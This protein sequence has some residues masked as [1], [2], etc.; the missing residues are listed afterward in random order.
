MSGAYDRFSVNHVEHG[1]SSKDL[2]D[3]YRLRHEIYCLEEQFLSSE[4]YPDGIQSDDYDALSEHFV[5]RENRMDKI[6]GCARL[7]KYSNELRFP[8]ADHFSELYSK[9]SDKPL[10]EVFEVS[11][12]CVSPD[13]RQRLVPKDGLYGI[14]SYLEENKF[15]HPE[16]P[17]ELR[18]YPIILLLMI[19]AMY[20]FSLSVGG[21]FWIASMEPGLIRYFSSCGMKW[22]HLADNYIDFY[23]RVM[24]CLIDLEKAMVQMSEKRPDIY[25]FLLYDE[26]TL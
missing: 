18:K 13:F 11:R 10:A 21:R 25:E 3:S 23:G 8:T 22:E 7:I 2:H 16:V 24:P 19:K 12:F 4:N 26:N 9:L 15:H 20:Q 6:A 1:G 14:E 17:S 5:V